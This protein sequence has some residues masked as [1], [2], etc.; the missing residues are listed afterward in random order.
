[1]NPD[2]TV[3]VPGR[4]QPPLKML[5]LAILAPFVAIALMASPLLFNAARQ[6]LGF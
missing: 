6:T 2:F 4:P 3:A 1:M 5:L